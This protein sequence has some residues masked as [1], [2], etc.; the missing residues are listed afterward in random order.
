MRPTRMPRTARP[1]QLGVGAVML[2]IPASALA[3]SAGQA[4]TQSAVPITLSP[5]HVAFGHQVTVRGT[6]TPGDAGQML[7]L[8]F[9]PEAGAG[10][11]PVTATT[12]RGDGTFRF[13]VPVTRSGLVEVVLASRTPVSPIAQPGAASASVTIPN[14]MQRVSV[15][16]KFNLRPRSVDVLGGQAVHVRGRLT[17]ALA[18]RHVRLIGRIRRSW[19]VIANAQTGR[20]GGFDLHYRP[21][22]TGRQWLRVRFPGDR[23]NTGSWAHAGRVNVFRESLASWYSDGG[24]T[25]C[26]FHAGFGVANKSLPCGTKVTFRYGGRTVTATVD[27]RG[28]YVGGREWD[29]NQSTAGALG[30]GGVGTVW[31]S[32]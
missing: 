17:P 11:Q 23:L 8:K 18:G 3:L 15:S 26:G 20:R 31:S 14:A 9:A 30:F 5:H 22:S 27:D 28:P 6:L 29:L 2:A 21:D 7:K 24:A 4:D 12:V 16:A 1:V 32:I 25:A 19:H 13:A 10:W